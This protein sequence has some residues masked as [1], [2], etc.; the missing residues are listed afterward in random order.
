MSFKANHSL[1]FSSQ[2]GARTSATAHALSEIYPLLRFVVQMSEP[3]ESLSQPND[4][5]TVERRLAGALQSTHGAAIYALA[6]P[7]PSPVVARPLLQP[8]IQAELEAHIGVLSSNPNSRMVLTARSLSPPGMN[9]LQAA[10][11]ARLHDLSLL[12]LSNDRE[13]ETSEMRSLV[14]SVGNSEGRLVVVNELRSPNSAAVAFEVR[15]QTQPSEKAD[16]LWS[17]PLVAQD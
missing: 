10:A 12:Q 13:L 3:P 11:K 8:R 14:Q 1:G 7:S 15:W 2:V 6:V 17:A 5:I 4:R 9:D 16:G